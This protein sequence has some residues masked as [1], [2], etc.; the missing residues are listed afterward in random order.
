MTSIYLLALCNSRGDRIDEAI[1]AHLLP[2]FELSHIR[3]HVAVQLSL[4]GLSTK[5]LGFFLGQALRGAEAIKVREEGSGD[6]L[7]RGR[8]L[9]KEAGAM[10]R[11]VGIRSGRCA[12]AARSSRR[13]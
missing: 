1:P 4:G 12:A 7:L 3:T 9:G 11:G 13:G 5:E 6:M 2:A 10:A 8:I